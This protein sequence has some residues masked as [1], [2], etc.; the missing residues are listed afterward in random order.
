MNRRSKKDRRKVNVRVL[1]DSTE[2]RKKFD[3]RDDGVNVLELKVG[4][5]A[6]SKIFTQFVPKSKNKLEE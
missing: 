3:R 1:T 4:D 5:E 2:R 6:F